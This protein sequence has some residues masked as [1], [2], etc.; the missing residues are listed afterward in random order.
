MLRALFWSSF[1]S[2]EENWDA[3]W[4]SVHMYTCVSVCVCVS[5]HVQ[6]H[7]HVHLCRCVQM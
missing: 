2:S 6:E 4:E 1:I 3:Y 5:M 7:V